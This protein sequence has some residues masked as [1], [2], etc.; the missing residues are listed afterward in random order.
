MK[1]SALLILAAGAAVISLLAMKQWNSTGINHATMAATAESGSTA[2]YKKAMD[3]MM[4]NMKMT[5][6][7]DPDIDFVRSMIPHH[8]G[9]IAMAAVELEFGK[10]PEAV[11]LATEIIKAQEGEIAI[12]NEWL[13]K[14]VAPA[15]QLNPAATKAYEQAMANMMTGMMVPYSGDADVDLMKGMIPHHQAAI[16]MAKVVLEHGKDP[17]IRALAESIIAA[18]ERE[19]AFMKDWLAKKGLSVTEPAPVQQ[20]AYSPHADKRSRR[21]KALSGEQVSGLE[22]A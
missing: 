8:Q 22:A 18:Q 9:A 15:S 12:M 14:N 5:Y 3:A 7:G 11:K 1:S 17:E 4:Q 19:I 2:A 16:D 21:I 13:A 10:D 20:H 6:T